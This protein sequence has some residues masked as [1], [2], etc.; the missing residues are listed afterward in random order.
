VMLCVSALLRSYPA[1]CFLI[2][3]NAMSSITKLPYFLSVVFE[4][5]YY[6][7]VKSAAQTLS[8]L[9]VQWQSAL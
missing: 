5:V 9:S 4:L 8:S 3:I 6:R 1:S 2:A 7:L